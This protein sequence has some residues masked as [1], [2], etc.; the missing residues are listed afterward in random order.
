MTDLSIKPVFQGSKADMVC[1]DETTDQIRFAGMVS[2]THYQN[3]KK[4]VKLS[5]P[6]TKQPT[7]R[8]QPH[9]TAEAAVTKSPSLSRDATMFLSLDYRCTRH[10]PSTQLMVSLAM[11]AFLPATE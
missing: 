8:H 5:V 11:S 1:Q 3:K 7:R 6:V 9:Q 4:Q 2:Q 10:Q